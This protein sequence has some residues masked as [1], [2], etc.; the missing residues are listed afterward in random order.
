M[1]AAN[2]LFSAP[3]VKVR[4]TTPPLAEA[5]AIATGR[6]L[7]TA[8]ALVTVAAELAA[9]RPPKLSYPTI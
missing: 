2:V 9:V 4:V 6:G 5:V 3:A 7:N 1:P 8:G